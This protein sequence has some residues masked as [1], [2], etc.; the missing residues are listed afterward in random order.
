[1]RIRTFPP[2]DRPMSRRLAL[3][4][5]VWALITWGGRINLLTDPEA[6]DPTTWLRVGASLVAAAGAVVGLLVTSRWSRSL[7]ATYAA[8]TGI[9]WV[10][11][12]VSVWSNDHELGFRLV[13][14][15]LAAVSLVLAFLAA[16]Q[17]A[18]LP[19]M[20]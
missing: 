16:R 4:I 3:A 2:Y 15:L 10:V 8:V 13:H 1:M 14:T 19:A 6:G 12:L 9:V 5:G 20:A 11:S 18:K 17:A 7:L